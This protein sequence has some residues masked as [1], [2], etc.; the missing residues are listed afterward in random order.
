VQAEVGALSA[1]TFP[2]I[3]NGLH[4]VT[5]PEWSY[6]VLRGFLEPR[7]VGHSSRSRSSRGEERESTYLVAYLSCWLCVFALLETGDRLI[8]PETFKTASLMASGCTFGLVVPVLAS[9]YRGLNGIAHAAKPSYSR[10]FF[11]CHYL[12]G[13]LVHFF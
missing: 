3:R 7:Q 9:L 2:P 6:S 5:Q 10:S 4:E 13:W 11:T 8:R 1:H 12:Y